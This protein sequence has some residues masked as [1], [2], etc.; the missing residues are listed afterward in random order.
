MCII[1]NKNLK[2]KVVFYDLKC[3]KILQLISKNEI[4][5]ILYKI[6]SYNFE[7]KD[8]EKIRKIMRR[9]PSKNTIFEY[10]NSWKE[11]NIID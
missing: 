8:L 5:E 6:N 9:F 11:N 4:L 1:P 7:K 10:R 2:I 3:K